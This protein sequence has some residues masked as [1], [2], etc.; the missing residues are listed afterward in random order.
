MTASRF[1]SSV[2]LALLSSVAFIAA[3][4]PVLPPQEPGEDPS[5][6]SAKIPSWE[7]KPNPYETSA[8]AGEK[9]S[10]GGAHEGM[11]HG[12]MNEGAKKETQPEAEPMPAHEGEGR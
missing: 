6:E 8:F 4:R 10:K 5:D 2:A 9:L 12:A 11:D 1:D 7:P 3:C